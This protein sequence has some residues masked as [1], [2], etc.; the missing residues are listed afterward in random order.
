MKSEAG[1]VPR[2]SY[3]IR[4]VERGLRSRLDSTLEAEGL[5]TQE[6][7]A[8]SVLARRDGLSSA[9]LARRTLVSAQAMNQLVIALEKRGLITRRP[10]PDHGKIQRAT[11]TAAGRKLVTAGD[12]A[13]APIEARLLSVLS[14]REIEE[15]RRTLTRCLDALQT[16]VEA[17]RGEARTASP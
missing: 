13:S 8:L 16:D 9:Q 5:S 10:D 15:F 7:T 1:A 4:W 17:R 11:L 12:R 2:V 6:Y 14:A 3:L